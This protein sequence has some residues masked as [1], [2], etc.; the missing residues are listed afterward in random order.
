MRLK[1]IFSEFFPFRNKFVLKMLKNMAKT[2]QSY[3]IKYLK[4]FSCLN[5][6]VR[7]YE[8]EL[9]EMHLRG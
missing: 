2:V 8:N 1:N 3:E 5:R 7:K 4:S 6:A 9:F